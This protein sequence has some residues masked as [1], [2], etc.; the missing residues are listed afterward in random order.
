MLYR[1]KTTGVVKNQGE[2]RKDNQ[3]TSFPAV[4][5]DEVCELLNIEPVL[6]G[7]QPSHTEYQ[8]I[9]QDGIE[10]DSNGNWVTKFVVYD[11]DKE[12]IDAIDAG[13]VKANK[14]KASEMLTASDF[15]DLPNTANK[16]SNIA[17]IISYRDALRAIALNPTKDAEFPVKPETVWA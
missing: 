12:T 5:N 17:D 9:R 16:I 6:N 4:W 14:D 13:K 2:I 10:Q 11:F 1:N 3:N 8:G 7:A 15:Y